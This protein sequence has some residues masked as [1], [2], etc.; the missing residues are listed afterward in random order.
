[1]DRDFLSITAKWPWDAAAQRDPDGQHPAHYR[2]G[3]DTK[4]QI[5]CCLNCPMTDCN[6]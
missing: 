1:M 5:D 4:E 3:G 2:G 6:N